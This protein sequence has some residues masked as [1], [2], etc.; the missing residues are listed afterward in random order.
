[1]EFTRGKT[2]S[3]SF[4]LVTLTQE[5]ATFR[6]YLNYLG[7]WTRYI[8]EE[9][10]EKSDLVKAVVNLRGVQRIKR[11][12]DFDSEKL[13]KLLRNA[14]LTEIQH[15]VSEG[16]AEFMRY[17]NHWTPV[18]AYYAVFL[19]LSALFV[20][21]NSDIKRYHTAI[22]H[23]IGSFAHDRNIFVRP[24]P[25]CVEGYSKNLRYLNFPHQPAK[26]SSLSSGH[27]VAPLDSIAMLLR[28]TREKQLKRKRDEWLQSNPNRKKLSPAQRQKWAKDLPPTTLFD[29]F[30]RLRIRSNYEDADAFL[31]G[32]EDVYDAE[33]FAKAL[34]QIVFNTLLSLEPLIIRYV[35]MPTFESVMKSFSQR[36]NEEYQRET[37]LMRDKIIRKAL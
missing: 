30:Y 15:H 33:E 36:V 6:T 11:N 1:M 16:D 21:S 8:E 34:K 12:K 31:M 17:S 14:W 10:P 35:G 22:L 5:E 9:Y 18:Q 7:A 32:T 28:T 3:G 25:L 27:R 13:S 23:T 2:G 4:E 19:E 37:I 20:A 26:I 24:W 29:A